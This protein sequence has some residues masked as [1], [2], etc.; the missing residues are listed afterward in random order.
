M[1]A[2]IEPREPPH[3]PDVEAAILGTLMVHGASAVDRVRESLTPEDFAYE[4]HG[5]LYREILR[6]ADLNQ[7][8][9]QLLLREFADQFPALAA[10]GGFKYLMQLTLSACGPV[11]LADYSRAVRSCAVRRRI[12]SLGEDAMALALHPDDDATDDD[13]IEEIERKVTALGEKTEKQTG[14]ISVADSIDDYLR[15]IEIVSKSNGRIVGVSTGIWDVDR[16][17]GGLKADRLIVLAARPSMGKTAMAMTWALAAAKAGTGVG[18]FELEM[19]RRQLVA[20]LVAAE[21]GIDTFRQENG[22]LSDADINTIVETTGKLRELPIYIDDTPGLSVAQ[23]RFRARRLKRRFKIG[24]IVA[25]HIQLMAPEG[26]RTDNRVNDV[27]AITMGL[28]G[29]AKDLGIPVVALSQLNRQLEAREDKRPQ[30]SDLRESGSIEQDAD[31]VLFLFREQYYLERN[32][33]M[34][35]SDESDDR[36]SS[37]QATWENQVREAK[38]KAELINAK[39]R[40]GRTG[41]TQLAFDGASSRFYGLQRGE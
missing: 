31:I 14:P 10:V 9:D 7:K 25:D 27:S 3:R 19:S 26:K 40:D 32:E 6:R 11:F 33:P 29:I 16:L 37:R 23:V 13:L 4:H 41:I 1:S 24:L 20:R 30:L 22:P 38:G 21:T 39:S 17:V 18:F 5:E 12:M 36:F 35:R 15:E 8:I 28:K 2:V 34:R